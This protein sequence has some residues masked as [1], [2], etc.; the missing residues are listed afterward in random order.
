MVGWHHWLDAHGFWWTPGVG[1]VRGGLV[2][3]SPG[4]HKE[5]YMTEQ[6]DNDN[7]LKKFFFNYF[8]TYRPRSGILR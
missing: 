4:G 2:C 3:C 5:L 7:Q 6:L 8:S 1:D